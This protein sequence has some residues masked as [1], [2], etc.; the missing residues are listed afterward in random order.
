MRVIK[1]S[2]KLGS[3]GMW[4]KSDQSGVSL[5]DVSPQKK[6]RA[7]SS[8][9]RRKSNDPKSHQGPNRNSVAPTSNGPSQ[10][11]KIKRKSSDNLNED[12]FLSGTK[13]LCKFDYVTCY[14]IL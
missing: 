10:H 13:N 11:S 7:S 6:N 8:Q 4:T 1:N 14:K 5:P 2:N 3:E 12:I 9:T